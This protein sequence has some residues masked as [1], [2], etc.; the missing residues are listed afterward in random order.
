[1]GNLPSIQRDS[2]RQG[3]SF[4][5]R[6]CDYNFN[7]QSEFREYKNQ[8]LITVKFIVIGMLA[9]DGSQTSALRYLSN[10]LSFGLVIKDG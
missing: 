2:W 7:Q 8:L 3:Y 1:M 6:D 4:T 9:L 5:K 10:T